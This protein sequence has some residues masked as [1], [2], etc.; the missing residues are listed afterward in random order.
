MIVMD[1]EW[2]DS[3]KGIEPIEE[4]VVEEVV[5]EPNPQ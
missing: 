2:Y 4:P 1:L 3:M 5:V